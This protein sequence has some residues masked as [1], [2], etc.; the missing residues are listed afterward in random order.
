MGIENNRISSHAAVQLQHKQQHTLKETKFQT[1]RFLNVLHSWCAIK[2]V[3]FVGCSD[4]PTSFASSFA[5]LRLRVT[6]RST[7]GY[8]CL[9]GSA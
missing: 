9:K 6:T 1:Y 4:M 2:Y 7:M 8:V 3:R 5:D